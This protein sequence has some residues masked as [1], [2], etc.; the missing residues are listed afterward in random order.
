MRILVF[1]DSHTDVKTCSAVIDRLPAADMI[2]HAGDHYTD[3]HKLESLY[4]KLDFRYV[5]GNCDSPLFINEMTFEVGGKKV[6]LSHGHRYAV[7]YESDYRTLIEK[8]SSENADIAIFGHTHISYCKQNQGLLLLNPGSIRYG[9]TFGII[10]I[11][12]GKISADIC[13]ADLWV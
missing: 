10:E 12:D 5:A 4:P 6:F 9:R 2:I 7:K 8:S 11:E 3:A 13:G 1:S